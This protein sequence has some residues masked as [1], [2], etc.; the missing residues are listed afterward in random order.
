MAKNLDGIGDTIFKYLAEIEKGNKKGVR[1]PLPSLHSNQAPS[2]RRE[3]GA[4]S[5]L[6]IATKHPQQLGDGRF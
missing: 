6:S 3:Y 2:A 1:C 4:A 5:L